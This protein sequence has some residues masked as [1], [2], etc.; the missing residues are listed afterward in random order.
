[1]EKFLSE[2]V[3]AAPVKKGSRWRVT[4]AT[5]GQGSSGFYSPEVLREY[6]PIAFPPGTKA[7]FGHSAPGERDPRDQLGRY[8]EGTFWNEEENELQA[9]LEPFPRWEPVV[10]EMGEA[11]EVSMYALDWEKDEQGNI[12]RIG[13]HRGNTID[14]VAFGGLEGSRVKEKLIES[15][16][17]S[18]RAGFVAESGVTSASS[19]RKEDK[20]EEK[21]DKLIALFESFISASQAKAQEEVQ[22]KVDA[23]AIA[24]AV[25]ES[26]ES[27]DAKRKLVEATE[28]LPSQRE[29]LLE[30]ARQG[31]DIAP[32]VENAKKVFEEAK[33]AL[34]E[35]LEESGRDFG[36]KVESAVRL[37]EVL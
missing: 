36:H 22:A 16:A 6:G 21:L 17:E 27:Y 12:V 4:V 8:P 25:S 32:L 33:A 9:F 37:G 15:L 28:L 7:Y 34:T 35:S 29:S 14:A 19:E 11:L 1:M 10:E 20:L 23:E 18:A 30:A 5:P 3:A 31:A 13:P 24:T 2:S 26:L